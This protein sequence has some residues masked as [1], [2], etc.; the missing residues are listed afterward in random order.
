MKSVLLLVLAGLCFGQGFSQRGFLELQAPLYPQTAPNDSGR[1]IGEALFR[2]EASWRASPS[3]RFNGAIDAR[4]DTHKQVDRAAHLSWWDRERARPALA[5]RRLSVLW[6]RGPVTVEAG[7]QFIRWGK[8]DILNPTDR[9]APR[10]F[11][12]VVDNEFLA[13]P[14]ARLTVERGGD[15]IDA[16]WQPLFVPSRVPLLNQRWVVLPEPLPPGFSLV[17]AGARYPGGSQFGARWNHI[18]AGYEYSVSFFDG[19]NHLPNFETLVA[20]AAA[21]LRRTYPQMRMYGADAAVPLRPFTLKAEAAYFTSSTPQSPDYALYVLQAEK[22]VGEWSLVGGYAGEWAEAGLT[23][24]DFA[25]DRGLARAFLGRASY[26]IDATRTLMFEAALRQNGDGIWLRSEYSQT[27]GEHWRATAGFTLIRGERT[28]FL[29][30]YRRNSHALLSW[31][32]SF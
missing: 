29:G 2:Y 22:D 10:D 17:D 18:G 21:F 1:A 14:A 27:F 6:N 24:A 13:V 30:Q 26:T 5:V 9:F 7:K 15:T 11:L 28:D 8:A 31:R 19:F 12:S 16:V 32:Y 23:P 25:P 3:W 20:G 4:A